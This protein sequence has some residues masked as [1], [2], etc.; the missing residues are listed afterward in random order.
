RVKRQRRSQPGSIVRVPP[1]ET[2]RKH[3]GDTVS[4]HTTACKNDLAEKSLHVGCHGGNTARVAR[5]H[6]LVSPL[7]MRWCLQ[8]AVFGLS[9]LL[10]AQPLKFKNPRVG[11]I[12]SEPPRQPLSEQDMQRVQI[13]RVGEPLRAE[14]VAES[15]DAM[16]AT[17]R[18]RD[19]QVAAERRGTGV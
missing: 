11:K 8:I 10:F 4:G 16:F 3:T 18:Y 9:D 1:R 17:G 19:I 7:R 13:V 2:C 5:I 14:D 15:I 6:E 12:Q